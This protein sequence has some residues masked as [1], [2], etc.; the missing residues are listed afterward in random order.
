MGNP[1]QGGCGESDHL[2][3]HGSTIM[4]HNTKEFPILPSQCVCND[5]GE[6]VMPKMPNA[7]T[8]PFL[9]QMAESFL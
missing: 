8:L 9:N 1:G 6:P 4:I 3:R 7:Q 2:R 5:Y